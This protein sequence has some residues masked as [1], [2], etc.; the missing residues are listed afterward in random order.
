MTSASILRKYGAVMLGVFLIASMHSLI[1]P[2]VASAFADSHSNYEHTEEAEHVTC[3]S[4]LHQL[5]N[6]RD[7]QSGDAQLVDAPVVMSIVV[8]I[9]PEFLRTPWTAHECTRPDVPI[10]RREVLLL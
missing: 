10:D 9:A 7:E 3:P 5:S 2:E 6:V 1:V 8:A 4:S